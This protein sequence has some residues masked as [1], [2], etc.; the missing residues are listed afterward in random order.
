MI[1]YTTGQLDFE[2]QFNLQIL[3]SKVLKILASVEKSKM[4]EQQKFSC[5]HKS[6]LSK[7]FHSNL[8]STGFKDW[9]DFQSCFFLI[10][11]E[12]LFCNPD[13]FCGLSLID[14]TFEFCAI[15]G[16]RISEFKAE[17]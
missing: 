5:L 11:K 12:G 6:L 15:M 2:V 10:D 14:T 16:N 4:Q 7:H 13:H 3:L 9:K 8:N 17:K 1:S